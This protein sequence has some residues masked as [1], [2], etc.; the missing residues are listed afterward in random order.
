MKH[1]VS[2]L[3]PDSLVKVDFK[4]AIIGE[5]IISE[6]EVAALATAKTASYYPG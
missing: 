2:G 1:S 5:S 3:D 4:P 6:W